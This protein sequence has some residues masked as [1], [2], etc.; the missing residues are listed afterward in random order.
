L[1]PIIK[2]LGAVSFFNDLAS[3]MLYPLLPALVTRELGAGAMTLG[4]LDGLSDAGSSLA[5]LGSGWLSDRKRW[6]RPLVIAGYVVAA[7]VRPVIGLAA[8]G[9]QVVALRSIDRLGKGARTPPRDALIADATAEEMRGRAFGFQRAMDH[10][11]AVAGPLLATLLLA[12]AGLGSREVMLWTALP[13]ALAVGT[14]WWALYGTRVPGAP[15]LPAGEAQV[16]LREPAA[17]GR[18]GGVLFWLVVLFAFSRMPEA[19]MLLRLHDLGLPVAAAPLLWAVLHVVRSA[20]SY[21]GGYLSDRLGPG[22]MMVLGWL[23]YGSVCAALAAV[24]SP[25][26]G[27][28]CFASF[29]LVAAATEPAER[30]YVAA[31]GGSGKMGRAFGQYHAATGVAA[32]PGGWLLGT[33]YELAGGG[34]ALV[35]SGAVAGVLAVG[36]LL[37]ELSRRR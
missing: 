5:K 3:E 4:V 6:R 21:P 11:G 34:T 36:V 22:R 18:S 16:I 19:L 30:S 25:V 31:L 28:V 37:G 26:A 7:A 33:I 13:G 12:V 2:L 35:L 27:A 14:A 9:W 1:P 15:R 10:A 20:A 32:L 29:G 23:L 17:V 24:S 8:S